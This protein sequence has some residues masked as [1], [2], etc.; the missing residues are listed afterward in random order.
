MASSTEK[1]SG[2]RRWLRSLLDLRMQQ[3]LCL[4]LAVAVLL[5]A[6]VVGNPFHDPLRHG[7]DAAPRPGAAP[8]ASE[9][10]GATGRLVGG[11]A[12][13]GDDPEFAARP[14]LLVRAGLSAHRQPEAV[15][16]VALR[17]VAPPTTGSLECP[18]P[19]LRARVR[20]VEFVGSE[21]VW[22]LDDGRRVVKNRK[23]GPGE[24]LVV[25]WAPTTR[26]Q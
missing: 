16:A 1:P 19:E 26:P 5:A 20:D 13:D 7:A 24:P 23:V 10:R 22:V 6:L 8:P 12:P 18:D 17:T 11:M 15:N 25:E 21:T 9:A 3:K 2:R 4:W 14:E